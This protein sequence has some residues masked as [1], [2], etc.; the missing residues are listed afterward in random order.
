MPTE[1]RRIRDRVY[2]RK[3]RLRRQVLAG[4]ITRARMDAA[5]NEY[6]AHLGLIAMIDVKPSGVK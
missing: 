2:Q 1:R 5:L 3:R 6:A 4:K